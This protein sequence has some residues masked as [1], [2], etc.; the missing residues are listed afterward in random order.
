MQLEQGGVLLGP[1]RAS[2]DVQ[3]LLTLL[4]LVSTYRGVLELLEYVDKGG[5]TW[6]KVMDAS[7]GSGMGAVLAI[8]FCQALFFYLLAWYLD[9][10][11]DTGACH[12]THEINF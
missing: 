4:P 10:V 7:E 3:N 2:N 5:L 12:P 8:L 1:N 11:V 6:A 9:Q